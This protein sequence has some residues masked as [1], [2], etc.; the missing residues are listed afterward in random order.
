M[1]REIFFQNFFLYS[2]KKNK[3]HWRMAKKIAKN[4]SLTPFKGYIQVYTG[5]GKG[6][7][8]AA[9]GL[10]LRAAGNGLRSYI[11]QFMKGQKYGELKSIKSFKK[12][13]TIEQFG[14]KSFIHVKK[15]PNK[16]D[17]EMAKKGLEKCENAMLLGEYQIII[18]D[19]INVA[20]Y[21]NLLKEKDV[22][23][24]LKKKPENVE[25]ILT[26]RYAPKSFIEIADLVTEM[27]EIKHYYSKGIKARTGIEK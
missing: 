13:I 10:A 27:K 12:F 19:E 25:I 15:L 11:G 26:G 4:K 3:Y 16:E 24:F 23:N 5:N 2:K 9:I 8:T 22:I 14:K 6:K 20:V 1:K 7:T 21:F 18:L 17:V